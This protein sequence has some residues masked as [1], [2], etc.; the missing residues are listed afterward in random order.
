MRTSCSIFLG[1]TRLVSTVGIPIQ[2][3]GQVRK[4]GRRISA[5]VFVGL[6]TTAL[7]LASCLSTN[8]QPIGGG[9]GSFTAEPDEAQLWSSLQA[10]EG[11]VAPQTQLY[12]D[13][14]LNAYLAA[15]V[16]RLTPPGYA[17]AGG[18]PIRV[19]VRKDPRLNAA[20]MAHGVIVVNSGILAR[21]DGEA[22]LAAVLGHELTH[23]THRHTIREHRAAQNRQ[24]AINVA[25]FVGTLALA[26][27]AVDQANRGNYAA[28]QAIVGAGAPLLQVGLQLSYT[29]MVSGYS[30]DMETEADQQGI[31][32][33]AQAGYPPREMA[34]FFRLMLGDSSDRGSIE[35]FFWG[36]HPRTS[37]RIEAA[38][39]F[40]RSYQSTISPQGTNQEFESRMAQV[41]VANA[42]WDAY[43]GRT[44]LAKSQVDRT[45]RTIPERPDKQILTRVLYANLVASSSNGL[46]RRGQSAAATEWFNK[47]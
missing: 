37:E 39:A 29:A 20:A 35:T 23:I 2:E 11:K 10:A 43:L 3:V 24:T 32:L 1:L 41:R 14:R 33:M 25:A 8:L 27:A 19:L 18:P 13:Q 21:V 26:A 42:E 7:V 15:L 40:A 34:Q 31:R 45:L 17:S 4:A 30:R 47:A 28:S 9:T 16:T 46:S 12:Q 5:P 44:A 22:Q 38:E 36:S 6:I